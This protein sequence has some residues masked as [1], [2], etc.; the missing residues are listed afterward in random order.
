MPQ[1]HCIP[2]TRGVRC[3]VG[4]WRMETLLS[5]EKSGYGVGFNHSLSRHINARWPTPPLCTRS[6]I[7]CESW[8]V[9]AGR[10]NPSD[11]CV[12]RGGPA[13][14]AWGGVTA[15]LYL[16]VRLLGS[17]RSVPELSGLPPGVLQALHLGWISSSMC[18]SDQMDSSGH[19]SIRWKLL[20]WYLELPEACDLPLKALRKPWSWRTKARPIGSV[21]S[22]LGG[23]AGPGCCAGR[24]WAGERGA[25][26]PALLWAQGCWW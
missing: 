17:L 20:Y 19:R 2:Q 16:A 25:A 13:P 11:G 8:V 4:T 10:W 7:Q 6:V 12:S 22:W 15:G 18:R 23:A 14:S 9:V 24:G 26:R 1:I 5:D 3:A 21:G